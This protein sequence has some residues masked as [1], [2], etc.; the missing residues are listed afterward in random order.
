MYALL[1]NFELSLVQFFAEV[2]Q[3]SAQPDGPVRDF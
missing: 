3:P 1:Y 2:A